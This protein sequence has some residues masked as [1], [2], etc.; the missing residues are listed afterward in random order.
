MSLSGIRVKNIIC[1]Q[2]SKVIN[3]LGS[4]QRRM[5]EQIN[6][7]V[8]AVHAKN[9]PENGRNGAALLQEPEEA[10]VTQDEREETKH[11]MR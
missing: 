4:R 2:G 6:N 3:T 11:S 1:R 9:A 8:N 10:H 7:A 5:P